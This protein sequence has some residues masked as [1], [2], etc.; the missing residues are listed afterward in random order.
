MYFVA[1]KEA[2]INGPYF[3]GKFFHPTMPI[4]RVDIGN[5]PADCVTHN[6]GYS[7]VLSSIASKNKSLC[8]LIS[9]VTT[10]ELREYERKMEQNIKVRYPAK[11]YTVLNPVYSALTKQLG[12]AEVT[13][14][15]SKAAMALAFRVCPNVELQA[16]VDET[17]KYFLDLIHMRNSAVLGSSDMMTKVANNAEFVG[18]GDDGRNGVICS[19]IGTVDT[20]M[21]EKIDD[22]EADCAPYELRTDFECDGVRGE[23]NPFQVV[24]PKARGRTSFFELR[25]QGQDGFTEYSSSA[26]NMNHGMKRLIGRRQDEEEF[27]ALSRAVGAVMLSIKNRGKISGDMTRAWEMMGYHKTQRQ[28]AVAHAALLAE[29]SA[30]IQFIARGMITLTNECHRTRLTKMVDGLQTATSWAYH[31]TYEQFLTAF[32]PFLSREANSNIVHVKRALRRV[33]VNRTLLHTDDDIMVTKLQASLKRELAKPGKAPRLTVAYG[34]GSM[35]AGELPEFVKMCID[36]VHT[37]I[38]NGITMCIYI[39]AKPKSD[40][41]QKAFKALF[42]AMSIPQYVYV[43]IYSDDSCYSG[44]VNGV[45][46]GANVDIES[47]DSS[48]DALAFFSTYLALRGFNRQR[49]YGLIKQCTLPLHVVNPSDPNDRR[50]LQ[51]DTAIEGSGTTI[52]TVLNHKGS[53]GVALGTLA[54]LAESNNFEDSVRRGAKC[55]GH[56]VTVESWDQDGVMRFENAQFLKRSPVYV[57]GEWLPSINTG[58][59]I[60]SLGTVWD[61]LEARHLSMAPSEF[62]ATPMSVRMDM[63]FTGVIKGWSNECSNP[64]LDA[65]RARFCTGNAEVREHDSNKH[66]FVDKQDYSMKRDE[67]YGVRYGLDTAEI[68]EM[69]ACINNIQLGRKLSCSG[70]AKV[71]HKDY[72][73]PMG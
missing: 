5:E 2:F 45:S 12:T 52:T 44:C 11:Q 15:L 33:Y 18:Y 30:T 13:A 20:F 57:E 19:L 54:Q 59:V 35:Y 38:L 25:G 53:Y 27:R 28:Y 7:Y 21:A 26:N 17:V 62:A 9:T 24:P 58:C 32:E 70:F 68:A 1:N 23:F 41:L 71:F 31:K 6:N 48:Q 43:V 39:M 55:A 36:G 3:D 65:L 4:D 56:K 51:F 37:H 40:S 34:A 10:C 67:N 14:Q 50:V 64:I 29:Y 60:R 73:V 22:T 16:M 47:N 63:F 46:F 66:I 42:E 49:A 61:D 8:P 69:V 72:G